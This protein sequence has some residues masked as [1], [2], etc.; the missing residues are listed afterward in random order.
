MKHFHILSILLLLGCLIA[1]CARVPKDS[2]YETK[3]IITGPGAEDLVIDTVVSNFPRL[4]VS[5]VERRD[6]NVNFEGDIYEINLNTDESRPLKRVGEPDD[7]I[8]QPH[9]IDFICDAKG[10]CYLYAVSHLKK[11]K[12]KGIDEGAHFVVKYLVKQQELIYQ[13]TYTSPLFT[14]PNAV[15]A[16]PNGSFYVTNDAKKH[17]SITESMLKQKK[18]TVVFYDSRYDDYLVA[19]K[20]LAFANGISIVD[21]K[22]YVATT[23][24]GK[25]FVYQKD[26]GGRLT[27][28]EKVASIM[29]Q[30]NLRTYGDKFILPVHPKSFAFLRHY[31]DAKNISPT[32]V[33]TID[34][35]N[36]PRKEVLY[37][38]SGKEISAGTT[39]IIYNNHL[40]IGQVFEAFVLKVDLGDKGTN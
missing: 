34:P 28:P 10:A 25:L 27:S 37:A 22:V 2:S 18:S 13:A 38:D 9:G 36:R 3:R 4:L 8:F 21:D 24:Q 1:S 32:V 30:D 15:A 16:L 31:K 11:E 12:S 23:R 20:D 14:S 33:Y 5:C 6:R 35:Y 7:F 19:A 40:Y 17:L 39:G 29:G 26:A